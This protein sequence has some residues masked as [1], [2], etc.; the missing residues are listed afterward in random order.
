MKIGRKIGR[1]RNG[2]SSEYQAAEQIGNVHS[3]FMDS[4]QNYTCTLFTMMLFFV[5]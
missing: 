3:K 4:I 5:K 1:G 2:V